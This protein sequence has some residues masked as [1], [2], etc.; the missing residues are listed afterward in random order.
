MNIKL[1]SIARRKMDGEFREELFAGEVSVNEGL[2]GDSG[3]SSAAGEVTVLSKESWV[4]VCHETGKELTWLVHGS[5]LLIKGFEF[6]PT[7]LGKNCVSAK[8]NLK[9]HERVI[10]MK[11]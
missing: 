6:L 8:R 1:Q 10:Q 4:K 9:L 7:D 5:N 3:K 2:Q 11:R